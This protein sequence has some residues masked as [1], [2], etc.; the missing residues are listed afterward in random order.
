MAETAP[1]TKSQGEVCYART[2]THAPNRHDIPVVSRKLRH[3]KGVTFLEVARAGF[4]QSA[5]AKINGCKAP[6]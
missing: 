3:C 6:H 5:E 2:T 1:V 4:K